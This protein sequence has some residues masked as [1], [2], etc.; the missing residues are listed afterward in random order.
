MTIYKNDSVGLG[1]VMM[2][3]LCVSISSLAKACFLS[4]LPQL[5]PILTSTLRRTKAP[6]TWQSSF[7]SSTFR[8]S[9]YSW[10]LAVT[11]LICPTSSI[12]SC[13]M[14]SWSRKTS[15]VP[16]CTTGTIRWWRSRHRWSTSAVSASRRYSANTTTMITID[17]AYSRSRCRNHS[18]TTFRSRCYDIGVWHVEGCW[19]VDEPCAGRLTEVF[20]NDAVTGCNYFLVCCHEKCIYIVDLWLACTPSLFRTCMV[21]LCMC[22]CTHQCSNVEHMSFQYSPNSGGIFSRVICL[23]ELLVNRESGNI[24]VNLQQHLFNLN[25]D[26]INFY[27]YIH[28][29]SL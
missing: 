8:W 21:G 22:T 12:G 1:Y 17:S 6:C 20:R 27:N 26:E 5:E 25:P 7:R 15:C 16:N 2:W 3:I 11:R 19:W 18:R 23:R 14:A 24:A 29:N 9:T 28:R 4:Y 10:M 13:T